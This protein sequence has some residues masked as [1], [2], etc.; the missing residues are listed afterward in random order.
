MHS[1]FDGLVFVSQ[2]SYYAALVQA[3]GYSDQLV[4]AYVNDVG[5]GLFSAD[6]YL[7]VLAAMESWL[8]TGV[9]PDES[10]LPA[11][12]GFDLGFVPPAWPF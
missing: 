4:Q 12:K 2:E 7:S 5:H 6:Q 10:R 11:S 3:A 9:R 1:K 8:G